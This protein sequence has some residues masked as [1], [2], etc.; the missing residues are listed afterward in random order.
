[1]NRKIITTILIFMLAAAGMAGNALGYDLGIIITNVEDDGRLILKDISIIEKNPYYVGYSG[2]QTYDRPYT[3]SIYA[4][5][6]LLAKTGSN[7]PPF[8][9]IEYSEGFTDADRV[10]VSDG[11]HVQEYQIDFCNHNGLCEHCSDGECGLY[12]NELTCEDCLESS[13]DGFCSIREDGICDPDCIG[14]VYDEEPEGCFE[15]SLSDIGCDFLGLVECPASCEKPYDLNGRN[16]CE[17]CELSIDVSDKGCSDFSWTECVGDEFCDGEEI[18]L[19]KSNQDCC[20]GICTRSDFTGNLG[21]EEPKPIPFWAVIATAAIAIIVLIL[22]KRRL[23]LSLFFIILVGTLIVMGRPS[24][25]GL[26]IESREEQIK[27]VCE[28]AEAY[29]LP[30]SMLLTIAHKESGIQHYKDGKVK[31]STDGG[32]GMMQVDRGDPED[33]PSGPFYACGKSR[34]DGRELDAKLLKDNIECGALELW[35]K[36]D[37]LDCLDSEKE[38]FCSNEGT[39]IP[40]KKVIYEGW[41]IAIRAYNGWGCHAPYYRDLW[42][43]T[44]PRY[45]NLIKRVQS[46]VEDFHTIESDYDD[47]CGDDSPDDP[48]DDPEPPKDP[49]EDDE[50]PQDPEE[51]PG[52]KEQDYS[53]IPEDLL[54]GD[55]LGYYYLNPSF[56]VVEKIDVSEAHEEIR[57]S[58]TLIR[59]AIACKADGGTY[60]DCIQ[61]ILFSQ[62]KYNWHL[63]GCPGE[64]IY[65]DSS[66]D[67]FKFCVEMGNIL[68]SDY[69]SRPLYLRFALTMNE[70]GIR[71]IGAFPYD[72]ADDIRKESDEGETPME[73]EDDSKLLCTGMSAVLFGDSITEGHDLYSGNALQAEMRAHYDDIDIDIIGLIGMSAYSSSTETEFE[74]ILLEQ[75]DFVMLW[76]GMNSNSGTVDAHENSYKEM[77]SALKAKGIKSVVLTPIPGCSDSIDFSYLEDIS[78]VSKN[79][80]AD[81]V[82]DVYSE[83]GDLVGDDCASYYA[84]D[85]VHING[86]AHR[87]IAKIVAG[88]LNAW[89]DCEDDI[90]TDEGKIDVASKILLFYGDSTTHNDFQDHWY[91]DDVI[92]YLKEES[93]TTKIIISGHPTQTAKYGLEHL[94]EHV[95]SKD[96]DYAFL[97]WGMN[98]NYGSGD[99]AD[100]P[101]FKTAL[102][103]HI[104]N[105][106]EQATRLKSAGITPV[107]MTVTPSYETFNGQEYNAQLDIMA[108]RQRALADELDITLIDTRKAMMDAA[109]KGTTVLADA[110]HPS[111]AGYRVMADEIIR[112][113]SLG[114][115]E[116]DGDEEDSS[117]LCTYCGTNK[118]ACGSECCQRECPTGAKIIEMPYYNQCGFSDDHIC[119]LGCGAVSTKM[120]LEGYGL[121]GEDTEVNTIFQEYLTSIDG[122]QYTLQSMINYACSKDACANKGIKWQDLDDYYGSIDKGEPVITGVCTKSY[123]TESCQEEPASHFILVVGYSEDYLIVH[124]PLTADC[125][126]EDG[127]YLVIRKETFKEM[128]DCFGWTYALKT[129]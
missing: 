99:D 85:G 60:P 16:C 9:E 28:V 4:D 50:E 96:P 72:T 3:I 65:V 5:E 26:A 126:Q 113:F 117:N 101:G 45:I 104:K 70:S 73:E 27:M 98:D 11:I 33:I 121:T 46:Y 76:F 8:T 66:S 55:K 40:S 83:F 94:E 2:V 13:K 69:S 37:A 114:Q 10:V 79:V 19:D 47:V 100:D 68:S 119:R 64:N 58:S 81:L 61:D 109:A 118:G 23:H 38:Y 34:M 42:G 92:S 122:T 86:E 116:Q 63:G 62:G 128:V 56:R 35:K 24:I 67:K 32:V 31:I 102:D 15:D 22:G 103:E 108:D 112:S 82:I 74:K 84:S 30:G 17:S 127:K 39:G 78:E 59:N 7:M 1:V 129:A 57:F 52:K 43:A 87:K 71:D 25:T 120:G 49:D 54:K 91:G 51:K 44:D 29:D 124:D 107:I 88:R 125:G 89:M 6:V 18:Y 41:D 14:Y 77:I 20:T 12:E 93:P 111:T 21:Y 123:M 53:T 110:A 48:P 75:P 80:G 90:Q 36:C 105:L 97:L 95:I 115:D 106:R